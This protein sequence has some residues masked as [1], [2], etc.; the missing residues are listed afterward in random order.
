MPALEI[1]IDLTKKG[2]FPMR[3]VTKP[4]Q[5]FGHKTVSMLDSPVKKR[6]PLPITQFNTRSDDSIEEEPEVNEPT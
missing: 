4:H 2:R 6:A 1:K 3:K 5:H